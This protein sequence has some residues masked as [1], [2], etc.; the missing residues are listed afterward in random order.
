MLGSS[1]KFKVSAALLSIQNIII[2]IINF[3][4]QVFNVSVCSAQQKIFAIAC[5]FDIMQCI[6]DIIA[7]AF[8]IHNLSSFC[9]VDLEHAIVCWAAVILIEEIDREAAM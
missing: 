6:F 4:R 9:I 8:D 3:F 7:C 2:I 5:A 1:K